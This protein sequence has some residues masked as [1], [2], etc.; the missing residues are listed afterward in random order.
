M[1]NTTSFIFIAAGIVAKHAF[2][3]PGGVDLLEKV[4]LSDDSYNE[5]IELDA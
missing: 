5:V 3:L 4:S 1:F 2:C